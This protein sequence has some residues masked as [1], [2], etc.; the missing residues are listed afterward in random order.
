MARG[1]G[2]NLR[3]CRAGGPRSRFEPQPQ[4]W[5]QIGSEG[6]LS[7]LVMAMWAL[8]RKPIRWWRTLLAW[9]ELMHQEDTDAPG[10]AFV[11]CRGD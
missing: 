5:P 11:L 2:L 1:S 10:S 4:G 9:V 3:S 6:S 7:G 8:A